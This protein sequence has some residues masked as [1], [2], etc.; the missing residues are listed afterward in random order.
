MMSLCT[1]L[2]GNV[3]TRLGKC[4]KGTDRIKEWLESTQDS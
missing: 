1:T 3:L 4:H 2:T